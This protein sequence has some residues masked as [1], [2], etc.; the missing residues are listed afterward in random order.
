[1]LLILSFLKWRSEVKLGYLKWYKQSV[2]EEIGFLLLSWSVD[3][4]K[5]LYMDRYYDVGSIK[6]KIN[7]LNGFHTIFTIEVNYT[8]AY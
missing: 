8:N 5:I 7:S 6:V 2:K 4:H 3:D 1:M